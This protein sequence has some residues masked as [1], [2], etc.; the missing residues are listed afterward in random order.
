[1]N[2]EERITNNEE[3]EFNLQRVKYQSKVKI[4]LPIIR[5]SFFIIRFFV[6]RQNFFRFPPLSPPCK[7]TENVYNT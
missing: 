1:M 2:N 3:N 4:F 6:A 5:Y 7:K